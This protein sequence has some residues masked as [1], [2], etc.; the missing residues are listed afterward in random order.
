[1]RLVLPTLDPF[2]LVSIGIPLYIVTMAGQ[3]VPGFAVLST[4]GYDRPPARAALATSGAATAVGALFGAHAL[5]LAAITAA[6][7]AGPDAHADRDRRWIASVTSGI[8][9]L[10]LAGLSGAASVLVSASAPV[11][12]EAVAGLALLGA[13]AGAVVAAFEQPGH[14]IVAA[15]T[16][17]TVASGVQVVGI[18]APFWGLVAGGVVM[19]WLGVRRRRDPGAARAEQP[20]GADG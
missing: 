4:F 12:I 10:A 2:V 7:V 16:F 18:G 13:L 8:A 14:R 11:L 20:A 3:N 19:L 6:M 15:V 9:Y 1:V 5:N 17:L